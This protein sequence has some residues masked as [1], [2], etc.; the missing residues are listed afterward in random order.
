MA[1][2]KARRPVVTPMA[3]VPKKKTY[4]PLDPRGVP[5][6]VSVIVPTYNRAYC[7]TKSI[8]SAL[9]QTYRNIEVI[10]IDEIGKD[11][12]GAGF[13]PNVL[14]CKEDGLKVLP[15]Q[16]GIRRIFVRRLTERTH[17]NATG[18]GAADVITMRLYKDI[19]IAKTIRSTDDRALFATQIGRASCR[20]RV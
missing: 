4:P 15:G 6:L 16:P 17:G 2:E 10:I 13:D 3:R 14:G 1:N 20:E 8:D 11:V 12:S 7:V 5:G 18:V 9:A 19:D